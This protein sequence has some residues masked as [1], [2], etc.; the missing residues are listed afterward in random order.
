[1]IPKAKTKTLKIELNF[2]LKLTGYKWEILNPIN[3][4]IYNETVKYIES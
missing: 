3:Q 2:K 4:K 1:M